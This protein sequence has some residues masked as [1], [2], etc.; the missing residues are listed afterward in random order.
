MNTLVLFFRPICL[1]FAATALTSASVWAQSGIYSCTD[2]QGRRITADRPIADCIDRP[3]RELN[4]SGTTLRVIPPT[5]TAVEREAQAARAREAEALRQRA[6]DAIRRDQA[7]LSRY[8]DRAAHDADRQ[9]ALAQTQVVVDAAE[10]RIAELDLERVELREEM[11]FY[12]KNPSDAPARLRRDIEDN[13]EA[14]AAQHRAIVGQHSERARINA[15][16]DEELAHLETLWKA[17]ADTPGTASGV[18]AGR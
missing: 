2:A 7:L 16:F 15:R 1:V 13:V 5:P 3:Q 17:M 8:P 14:V 4:R 18:S 9:A 10:K 12:K 11:E 6:R